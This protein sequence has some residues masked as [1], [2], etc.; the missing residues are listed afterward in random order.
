[1]FGKT[2][3]L[4]QDDHIQRPFDLLL[5]QAKELPEITLQSIS[6]ARRTDLLLYD[7]AQSMKP[8][9][10]FLEKEDVML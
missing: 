8:S 10:I 2:A 5:V 9:L 1:M 7:D 4:Y 3:L 6:E